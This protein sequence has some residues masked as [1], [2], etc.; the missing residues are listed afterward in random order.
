MR[1]PRISPI[2][3][4]IISPLSSFT[5]RRMLDERKSGGGGW[6][7]DPARSEELDCFQAQNP[8]GIVV[9]HVPYERIEENIGRVCRRDIELSSNLGVALPLYKWVQENGVIARSY[10]F[11]A[12][13][14]GR[15]DSIRFWSNVIFE[16]NGH[17]YVPFFDH[18][19]AGGL[20]P[21]SR[22]FVFSVMNE[23]VRVQNPD[24]SQYRLAIFQFPVLNDK[25]RGIRMY[26]DEGLD[27]YA[28]DVV[29]EMIAETYRIWYEVNDE[30]R[31]SGGR[32]A[33]SGG[34]I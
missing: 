29:S 19:R 11:P 6:S 9:P 28:F 4:A 1:L 27:L 31:R 7:Y 33:S 15:I 2:D 26:T 17:R 13:S 21:T 20:G 30:R 10:Q 16:F 8:L 12:L 18:R 3:L 23:Q 24:F 14:F 5:K 34:F 32:A 25:T 22:R